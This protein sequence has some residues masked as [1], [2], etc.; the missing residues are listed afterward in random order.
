MAIGQLYDYR[1]FVD[2]GTNLSILLP[3]LPRPDLQELIQ[4]AGIAIIYPAGVGFTTVS[5]K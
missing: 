3:E 1:R 4:S 2:A 5:K